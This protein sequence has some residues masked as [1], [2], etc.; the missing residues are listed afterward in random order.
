[1]SLGHGLSFPVW[2]A[3]TDVNPLRHKV[4][5][6]DVT[7]DLVRRILLCRGTDDG[8]MGAASF[9]PDVFGQLGSVLWQ[10][11]I[12]FTITAFEGAP[13]TKRSNVGI[14]VLLTVEGQTISARL[15]ATERSQLVIS[16]E[17]T[18]PTGVIYT[19]GY[20]QPSLIAADWR[21]WH[22]VQ[23]HHV[24]ERRP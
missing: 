6:E 21:T 5:P 11:A 23:R 2:D 19:D 8:E 14:G 1:M 22:Q 16:T 3:S 7:G 4:Y 9:H 20:T 15:I 12:E 17:P 10:E 13:T 18:V 24:H